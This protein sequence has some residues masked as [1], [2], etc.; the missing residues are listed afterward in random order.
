M[1]CSKE[2][3]EEIDVARFQQRRETLGTFLGNRRKIGGRYDLTV[4]KIG[5]KH[6]LYEQGLRRVGGKRGSLQEVVGRN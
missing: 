2:S 5:D 4:F 1:E 3:P 6:R